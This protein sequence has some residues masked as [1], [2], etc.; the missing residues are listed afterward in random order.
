MSTMSVRPAVV[1]AALACAGVG[2]PLMVLVML[3]HYMPVWLAV[4]TFFALVVLVLSIA[5]AESPRPIPKGY[6]PG[7]FT[8]AA[9]QADVAKT[10][11]GCFSSDGTA[12]TERVGH[13]GP[14]RNDEA[15][16]SWF[17]TVEL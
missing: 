15:G 12:G 8:K 16:L 3:N 6:Q 7:D 2:V 14:R 9:V 11:C 1:G 4:I 17:G 5:G 10:P 13:D